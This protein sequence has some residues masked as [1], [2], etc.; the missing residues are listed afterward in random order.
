[1]T[2]ATAFGIG[3]LLLITIVA[4]AGYVLATVIE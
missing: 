1:M 4:I 2:G 3:F